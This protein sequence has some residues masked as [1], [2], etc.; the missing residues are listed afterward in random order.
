ML[1]TSAI[2]EHE[3][4]IMRSFLCGPGLLVWTFR[5]GYDVEWL[6]GAPKL[7][8]QFQTEVKCKI[9]GFAESSQTQ[10][11]YLKTVPHLKG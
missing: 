10:L 7:C 4:S 9:R 8:N 2:Q 3:G 11:E 5:Q 1:S 6:K